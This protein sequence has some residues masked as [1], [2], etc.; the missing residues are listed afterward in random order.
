MAA[1]FQ[2]LVS[3]LKVFKFRIKLLNFFKIQSLAIV[4]R[5]KDFLCLKYDLE[6]G[7]SDEHSMNIFIDEICLG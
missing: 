7:F 5:A 1:Y 2:W 4:Q 6:L 3:K